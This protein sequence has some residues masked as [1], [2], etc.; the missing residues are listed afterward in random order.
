VASTGSGVSPLA[1]G[2]GAGDAHRLGGL[3]DRQPR[4]QA[5]AGHVGRRRVLGGQPGQGLVDVEQQV[6]IVA[7][8]RSLVLEGDGPG[9]PAS[10]H[11]PPVASVIDQDSLHR[12]GRGAEEAAAVGEGGVSQP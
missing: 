9:P 10:L 2:R 5:I 6:T 3:L 8:D 1:E 11:G 12:D 7:R 4:E